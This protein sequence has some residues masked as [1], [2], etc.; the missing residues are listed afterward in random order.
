MYYAIIRYNT[1][2]HVRAPSRRNNHNNINNNITI[3]NNTMNTT[4]ITTIIII[5]IHTINNNNNNNN[6]IDINNNEMQCSTLELHLV[7]QLEMHIKIRDART[8]LLLLI[9]SI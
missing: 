3:M 1:A 8:S 7:R 6:N 2:K 4:I 9:S 5:I